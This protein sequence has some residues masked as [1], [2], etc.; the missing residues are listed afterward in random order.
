MLVTMAVLTTRRTCCGVRMVAA[1]RAKMTMVEKVVY[2]PC[3][4]W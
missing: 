1:I 3:R 4:R 2:V